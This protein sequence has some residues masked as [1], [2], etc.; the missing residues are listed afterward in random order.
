MCSFYNV[1]PFKRLILLIKG[2]S[3]SEAELKWVSECVSNYNVFFKSIAGGAYEDYEIL[4]LNDPTIEE[5]KILMEEM[6][7]DFAIIVFIGHGATQSDRQLFRIN[8]ND[9][10]QAGQLGLDVEK[11]L[12]ILESCRKTEKGIPIINLTDKAPHYKAGGKIRILITRERAKHL[13][14]EQIKK[15]KNGVVICFA[16][17]KNELASNLFFSKSLLG[18]S[19][20]WYLDFNNYNQIL[21]IRELMKKTM[22]EVSILSSEVQT[23]EIKGDIDFPFAISKFLE[24]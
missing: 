14:N 17:S 4:P 21:G 16:S 24:A 12:I 9:V 23:P 15:C 22:N 6:K 8:E 18:I 20:N 10:I 7:S 2:Y 19:F 1:K 3:K 13:Y 11:Q 5:L